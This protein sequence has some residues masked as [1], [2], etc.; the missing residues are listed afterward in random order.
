[1]AIRFYEAR[2]IVL[3]NNKFQVLSDFLFWKLKPTEQRLDS[4]A[5]VRGG[6]GAITN[7]KTGIKTGTGKLESK[8]KEIL[9]RLEP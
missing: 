6:G 2:T 8:K 9:K 1:L 4:L 7:Q 3:G 5:L